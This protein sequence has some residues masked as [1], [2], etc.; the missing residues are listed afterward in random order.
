MRYFGKQIEH[1][2]VKL[3]LNH[4]VD[5]AELIKGAYAHVVLATGVTPVSYTHL[6]VYKR[7][8]PI[9]GQARHF[10]SQRTLDW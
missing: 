2:G 6:D 8:D 7:Q 3:Q 4:R 9:S 5:A 10:T 1:T